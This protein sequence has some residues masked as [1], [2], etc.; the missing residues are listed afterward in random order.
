MYIVGLFA[1]VIGLY[2]DEVRS[3]GNVARGSD[4]GVQGSRDVLQQALKRYLQCGFGVHSCRSLESIHIT[5]KILAYLFTFCPPGPEDRLK[6]ISHMLFGIVSAW[7]LSSH[8]RAFCRSSSLASSVPLTAAKH[9]ALRC[10]GVRHVSDDET[11][12]REKSLNIVE[13]LPCQT[14]PKHTQ[15]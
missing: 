6:L 13:K 10:S 12:G 9:R 4:L 1:T 5:N 7:R 15:L 2:D 3:C 14:T 11:T 8:I